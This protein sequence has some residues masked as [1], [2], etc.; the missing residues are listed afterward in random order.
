[1]FRGKK[2]TGLL[3]FAFMTV[4]MLLAVRPAFAIPVNTELLLLVDV[5]GSIDNTEFNLQRTGYAN[6]FQN[7]AVQN[8]IALNPGGI[9]VSLVYWSSNTEQT[10]AVPWTHLTDAAS[11]NAFATAISNAARLYSHSTAVQ[12]AL[13]YGGSLFAEDNGFE[14][15][16]LI[17]DISGD[18]VDNDSPGGTPFRHG[19]GRD[20]ALAAGV[21]TI[22]GLVIGGDAA[23]TNYYNDWVLGGGGVLFA[24]ANFDAFGT[25]VQQ[26]IYYEVSGCV[27]NCEPPPCVV[28]CGTSG[29]SSSGGDSSGG[30]STGG[31]STGGNSGD[32]QVPEPTSLLLLGSGLS[33]LALIFRRRRLSVDRTHVS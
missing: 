26:K 7:A 33:G 18:G 31:Y 10:Q 9:A 32:P 15:T 13:K 4:A 27:I 29:G 25:A 3:G 19:G 5:S 12:S 28:E 1:M 21:D 20:S 14:G 23:V 8:F 11:A 16:H 2:R 24:A 30:S 22:N 6:A 17:I